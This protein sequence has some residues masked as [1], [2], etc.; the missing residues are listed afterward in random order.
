MAPK[1]KL[2]ITKI[3]LGYPQTYK[4]IDFPP[5]P[6]LYLEFLECKDKI[7][8]DLRDKVYEPKW[9]N[10]YRQHLVITSQEVT[11]AAQ[12]FKKSLL[13]DYTSENEVKDIDNLKFDMLLAAATSQ[14]P[15]N[16]PRR[17][18]PL[19]SRESFDVS[20]SEA[21]KDEGS[22]HSIGKYVPESKPYSRSRSYGSYGSYGSKRAV[23]FTR[24]EDEPITDPYTSKEEYKVRTDIDD[25]DYRRDDR[26]DRRDDTDERRE[27]RREDRRDERRDERR[28]DD[29]DYRREERRDDYRESKRRRE[30]EEYDPIGDFLAA[31]TPASVGIPSQSVYSSA[32]S[33][34]QSTYTS[35]SSS[36]SATSSNRPMGLDDI[37]RMQANTSRVLNLSQS[38]KD[39]DREERRSE[40]LYK[41]KKLK[42]LYPAAEVPEFGPYTDLE[43]LEREFSQQSKHLHIESN[44]ENYKRYLQMG[45]GVMEYLVLRFLHFEEI[46]GFAAE[47]MIRMNQYDKIL[48]ELGEKYQTSP[49][50][51]GWP[52]EVKLMGLVVFNAVVFVFMKMLV[53]GAGN[54]LMANVVNSVAYPKDPVPQPQRSA[55][56]GGKPQQQP[57]RRKTMQAPDDIE[58]LFA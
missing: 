50:D 53:K 32:K 11:S 4:P 56:P 3:P 57:Q 21:V 37:N 58:K 38:T 44:V 46:Q 17:R 15:L 27:D 1:R 42:R 40:L 10:N 9:N 20:Y 52:P 48:Y 45:F 8:P 12:D 16:S 7:K 24:V 18:S 49:D 30:D 23:K 35:S 19:G 29:D 51:P 36:S 5:M 39:H 54:P 55:Q 41:L 31:D 25:D 33:S 34:T 28:E 47:Q 6:Q 13:K 22:P 43:T 14:V 26:K 2:V